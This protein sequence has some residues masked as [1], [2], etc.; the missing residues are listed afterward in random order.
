MTGVR[1]S[2]GAF[3]PCGRGPPGGQSPRTFS[4]SRG[5]MDRSAP[6]DLNQAPPARGSWFYDPK[7]RG[8]AYQAILIAFIVFLA[9]EATTNALENLRRARIASGFGFWNVTAGFDISQSLIPFSASGST[10]GE[11][12]YV[13]LLNTLIVAASGILFATLVGFLM[14]VARLSKNWL[15]ARLATIYVELV[16]NVPLLLQLFFWYY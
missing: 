8:A 10:Y 1:A 7:V 12:F 2:A 16:R 3:H 14:G 5:R 13:G 11:A 4:V 9:Y 15:I 6:A